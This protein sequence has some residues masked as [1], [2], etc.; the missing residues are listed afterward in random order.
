MGRRRG[1]GGG[2]GGNPAGSQPRRDETED[3][4]REVHR[5]TKNP[6]TRR[7]VEPL[8]RGDFFLCDSLFLQVCGFLEVGY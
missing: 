6:N 4:V 2:G 3:R 8:G 7:F 5:S 1:W